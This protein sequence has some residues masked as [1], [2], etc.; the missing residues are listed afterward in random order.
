ML[1]AQEDDKKRPLI[2]VFSNIQAQYGYQFNYAKDIIENYQIVP[3][4]EDLTFT[5]TLVYLHKVTDLKY[6]LISNRFVLVNTQ[7]NVVQKQ[8]LQ[9][10]PEII[11]PSYIIRGVS[12]LN[13]GSFNIDFSNFSMLPGLIETDVLQSIQAFP[14]IQSINE[15]VSNINIRGGSHDQN[16]ILWDGIKMYQSGHFFGLISMYNPQITQNVLLLK[17][18]SDVS[19]TDGVS[20]SI[21]MQTT[22]DVN[23]TF[24]GN[25]S[26]NFIDTNGF[27]DIPI[28]KKSSIQLALRKSISDFVETPAYD[29]FFNKI[30]EDTEV[31]NSM[32]TVMN[33]D[34][35]FDFYDASFRWIYKMSDKEELRVNFINVANELIF[36]ENDLEESRRSSVTQNSIAGAIYYDRVWND[37]WQTSLELYET[38]Y[39]LKAINVNIK[40]SQR[41]LQENIVSETSFKL[42]ANYKLNKN[43][44][45]LNGYHVVET[46]VTNL[47]DVDAPIFRSLVSEVLRTH[48]LFSQFNYSSFNRLTNIS[49]GIR[50]NYI[51]KFKKQIWEP[52]FSFTHK[53][54]NNFSVEVLGEMKHQNTSQVINF[55]ND[56]LG[57]E[58]RRWQLSNNSDI[59]IIK[60]K[61]VSI[62]VNYNRKGWQ[63]SVEA[64]HKKV[65][66]I[67]SQSQGFQNQYE[68]VQTSGSYQAN[69][70]DFI[71][72]KQMRNFNTW[73][74]YA[75][76]NSDYTFKSWPEYKFP[77]NYDISHA[78][79]LGSTYALKNLRISTG[80]NWFSGKPTTLPVADNAVIDNNINFGASNSS[81]LNDYFKVDISALYGFKIKQKTKVDLGAS[82]WNVFNRD[83]QINNFFRVNDGQVDETL[84][85]SLG[86]SPNIV[87]RVY[88]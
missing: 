47:D 29:N 56:F 3:P 26:V 48:G 13:N 46:K 54:R 19:Y 77:S 44:N 30:S 49:A 8:D 84:Q 20:G 12:K 78:L 81:M 17:N 5:E 66:G 2:S 37:T 10:L 1:Q 42:K 85:T 60:S 68:F 55:Q 32:N 21:L 36:N 28:N 40:D 51:D 34:K 64:Y 35:E 75:Y 52:R 50:F 87:M 38:D 23:T 41:F 69:G 61:Q 25:I 24:K 80:F 4:S 9:L 53:F 82:I 65:N 71:L 86:F 45:L 16:L 59:P 76:L 63:L 7:K 22:K 6:T 39:K 62:G 31:E 57:V 88:F 58:K 67:T 18:G 15:N 27:A 74:S 79:T 73:L 43:I 70:L 11:V 33:T 14:G 83:N 72:R